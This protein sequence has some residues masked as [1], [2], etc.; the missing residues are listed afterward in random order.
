MDKR[1]A[2]GYS[3][4]LLPGERD[5]YEGQ[6]NEATGGQFGGWKSIERSM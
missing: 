1:L 4:P 2:E 6:S 3:E 5:R